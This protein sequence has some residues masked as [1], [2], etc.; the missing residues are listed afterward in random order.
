MAEPDEGPGWRV[1]IGTGL[2]AHTPRSE[3]RREAFRREE[4]REPKAAEFEAELRQHA[5]LERRLEL[6]RQGVVPHS[7]EDVL[8][9]VSYGWT[10]WTA[11]SSD[12]RGRPLRS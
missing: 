10:V 12:G 11:S 2:F 6:Q 8:A 3:E 1:P 4:E 5:A 9:R 7:H